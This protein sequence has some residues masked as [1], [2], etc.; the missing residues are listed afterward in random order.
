[1]VVLINMPEYMVLCVIKNLK[2]KLYPISGLVSCCSFYLYTSSQSRYFGTR[3][4]MTLL[5]LLSA[6]RS[7]TPEA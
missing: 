5:V 3:I 6:I 2:E 7:D 1:M 4:L